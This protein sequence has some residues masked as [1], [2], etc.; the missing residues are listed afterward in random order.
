MELFISYCHKDESYID[1]FIKI[2]SPI[3]GPG[4][5]INRIWYDRA[6]KAGEHLWDKINHNID[7]K[8]IICLFLST[9]YLA[10]SSCKE[11]MN[12]ALERKK[13]EGILVVP[14]ILRPCPWWDESKELA[15]ILAAPQDAKPVSSFENEDDAWM[16]I[17]YQVKKATE[18]HK[19]LNDVAFKED[20][21]E[22]LNDST[23]FSKANPN[24]NTLLLDDI[25]VYPDLYKIEND[26]EI[27]RLPSSQL[28]DNYSVGERFV[29]VGEDQSG[30]TSL[31]KQYIKELKKRKFL[32]IYIKDQYE[33]LQGNFKNR[34]DLLFKEQYDCEVALS[35]LDQD[36]IVVLVDDFHKAK[37]K[38]KVIEQII[39]FKNCIFV[40]DDI[41]TLDAQN[42]VLSDFSRYEIKQLKPSQRNELIRKWI[43]AS[44]SND[45][46][47][48]FSNEILRKIDEASEMT[49]ATIGR[50]LGKG[51]MPAY[52]YFILT[53]LVVNEGNNKP[54]DENITS[55]GY[56]YQALIVLFLK[57]QGVSNANM[58]SYI[59]FLTELAVRIYDNYGQALN[60]MQFEDFI[61][62]YKNLYNFTDSLKIMLDKLD[63]SNIMTKTKLGNYEFNYPY[64]YYY[65]AGKYFAQVWED[66]DDPRHE[67]CKNKIEDVLLNLHKTSNAYIAVFI[68]HH[69]KNTALLKKI[70]FIAKDIFSNY[71]PATLD[72]RSLSIFS[73]VES[74][75]MTPSLPINSSP[76]KNRQAKLKKKDQIELLSDKKESNTQDDIEDRDMITKELRRSIKT[77]EVLG[78]ILKNRA[79]SLRNEQLESLFE[80]A[81]NI[82]FRHITNFLNIVHAIVNSEDK[83]NFLEERI[84]KTHPEIDGTLL[85]SKTNA[86]FW[87]MNFCFL[88]SVIKKTA[89]SLGSSS[90][91]RVAKSVCERTHS[92]ASFMLKHTILMW[93]KKNIDINELQKMDKILDNKTA[94][95]IMLWLITD[96]C[97]VHTIGY[98]ETSQLAQLGIRRQILLPSPDKET[99]K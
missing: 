67:Q 4:K 28:I 27:K 82:Q 60:E 55:Q 85:S 12:K 25:F 1:N 50:I 88:L 51:I 9:D 77:V 14:I 41:Y 34:I 78:S 52:A 54:L 17:Y 93:F 45:N 46:D 79:G 61:S 97:R 53:L 76:V 5:I 24:K 19:I 65:F 29:I 10:S 40:V 84:K 48:R 95:N 59:N 98:K 96:Y 70:Q 15:S 90:I 8:D 32:P 37:N 39:K 81:M 13:N 36:K 80:D 35:D 33:L 18:Q 22:F 47:V 69:T 44:E 56:C 6:I 94:K 57:K 2:M 89:F 11:E 71:E 72:K 49:E 3:T 42:D 26:G 20:F 68:A 87:G 31:I 66:S 62:Y 86:L 16:D 64:I 99:T 38:T 75:L 30:K 21:K 63:A 83:L 74:K 92:P 23:T 91:T 73:S 58:D 7:D 43:M